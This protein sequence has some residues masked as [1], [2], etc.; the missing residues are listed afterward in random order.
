MTKLNI[1][2]KDF[3]GELLRRK[4]EREKEMKDKIAPKF[5]LKDPYL[6]ELKEFKKQRKNR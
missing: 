1:N 2:S 6:E 4:A 5:K 3:V